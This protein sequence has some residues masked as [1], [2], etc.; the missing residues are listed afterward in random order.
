MA[1]W[2]PLPVDDDV[3]TAF[4]IVAAAALAALSMREGEVRLDLT[5]MSFCPPSEQSTDPSP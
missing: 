1:T 4:A 2:Q 3:V 5:A